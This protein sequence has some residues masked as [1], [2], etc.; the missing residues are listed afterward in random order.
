MADRRAAALL[1]QERVRPVSLAEERVLEV[2][3]AL[4]GLLPNRGLRR[5][6]AVAVSGSANAAVTSAALA[7]IA[8]VTAAGSW[9]AVVGLP[10]LGLA[11]AEELGLALERLLLIG[12][13][14]AEQWAATVVALVEAVDVV[15]VGPPPSRIGAGPACRVLARGRERGAV[16]VLA[17][18]PERS[19]PDRAELTLHAR[20]LAWSGIGRGHGYLQARQVELTISGRHGADM[21]RI[22]RFW[23][24]N[25]HGRFAL[26][27]PTAAV[28]AGERVNRVVELAPAPAELGL[29]QQ[30]A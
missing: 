30:S 3:P 1:L 13:V 15:V 2:H 5:G 14:P 4:A 27:E 29:A 18:W 10:Q 11:A 28:S 20:P 16:L 25:A 19:W 7:L 26:V 9:A 22:A 6:T 12:P 8:P 24:P 21:A 23:M 17:G